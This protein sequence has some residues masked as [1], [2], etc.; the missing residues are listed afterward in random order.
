MVMVMVMVDQT[1]DSKTLLRQSAHRYTRGL[2]AD[3]IEDNHRHPLHRYRKTMF[4]ID[5]AAPMHR[6]SRL[7]P[8]FAAGRA[9]ASQ[10]DTALFRHA[11]SVAE[12][13]P[14]P[15]DSATPCLW[16]ALSAVGCH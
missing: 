3:W 13:R 7:P 12:Q 11:Q 10:P 6:H 2:L 1:N 14:A 9:N 5:G 16:Q 15:Q 4:A 8:L